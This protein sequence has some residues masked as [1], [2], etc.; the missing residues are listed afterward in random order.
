[1]IQGGDISLSLPPASSSE[2]AP[3]QQKR[4]PF[5]VPKGGASIHHPDP[6]E[7]EIHLPT[8]RHNSRGV[9]SMASR[10]VK[11][12]TVAG[13][14]ET[15]SVNGSQ[16]FITFAAAPH[17]DGQSTVF[18]KVLGLGAVTGGGEGPEDTLTRLEKAKVKIDKKGRVVQ[19]QPRPGE[20]E[21]ADASERIGIERITIHANPFAG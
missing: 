14:T 2:P 15:K 9:L 4:L 16:F 3:P 10:M 19:P 11:K 13:G 5:E 6:L 20:E 1:M 7:P 21:E 18:G 17:L 12:P 8:L